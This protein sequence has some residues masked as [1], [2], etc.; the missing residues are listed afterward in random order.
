MV[1]DLLFPTRCPACCRLGPAPCPACT[2]ELRRAPPAPSPVG[3]RSCEAF[4]AY[5]DVGR[6]LVARLKYRNARDALGWLAVGMAGLVDPGQVDVVTWAPTSAAR[7]RARGFDQAELLA[8][9]LATELRR[10]AR[11]L[12]V[13]RPGPAQTGQGRTAR[14]EGPHFA[15]RRRSTG[16]TRAP[17]EGGIGAVLLVDDVVTTGSTLSAAARALAAAGIVEVHAVVAARTPDHLRGAAW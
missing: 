16:L 15:A 12:L 3:L 2:S 10:P 1:I 6:D 11:R 4:L 9:E 17:G 14:A 7:R 13:R 5:D 8:R